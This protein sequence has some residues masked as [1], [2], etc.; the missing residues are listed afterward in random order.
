M[1][2]ELLHHKIVQY[3]VEPCNTYNMDEKGFMIGIT[4]RSKRVFSRLQWEKKKVREA[5]QDGSREWVT[6]MAILEQMRVFCRRP[7]YTHQLT[8][9][10]M[11]SLNR[12]RKARRVCELLTDRIDE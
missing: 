5:L 6:V 7:S 9:R 11:G 3:E 12:S 2:F 1:Y 10:L 4:G 8:A